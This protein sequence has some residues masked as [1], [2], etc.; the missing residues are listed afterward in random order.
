MSA[1]KA[2]TLLAGLSFLT[3]AGTAA[4]AAKEPVLNLQGQN[5]VQ[6]GIVVADAPA[7]AR[8]YG[9]LFGVGP[10]KFYD[11]ELTQTI[12]HGRPIADGESV[13]RV[14]LAETPG[15]QLALLQPLSGPSSEREFLE[16]RGVGIHHLGFGRVASHQAVL[17]RLA[18]RGVEVEMQGSIGG[19]VTFTYLGTQDRL[20]VIFELIDGEQ[21][22]VESAVEPWGT[23][24]PTPPPRVETRERPIVQVGIVVDDAE[25]TAHDYWDLFGIGPWAFV[26][27]VPPHIAEGVLHGVTMV[28]DADVRVRG[29]LATHGSLEIE[30]LEP[31]R[32]PS[33]HME[34]LQHYGPGAH[35]LSFGAVA[36][37]DEAVAA[38]RQE[39]I[40][41]EMTGLLGGTGIF[42]YMATQ[43]RLGTIFELVKVVSAGESSLKPYGF[44]PSPD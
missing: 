2:A 16:T 28:E 41:I 29:A 22:G 12:E 19:D 40:E 17:S 18:Q 15:L 11:L 37:H 33:T 34:F 5:I 26:D 20:G 23:Y 8:E 3:G 30:L 21:S 35:H 1:R 24:T 39:G 7:T 27:F 31:M 44:F 42:T 4:A 14:A 32:G 9:E 25:R 6:V 36:D 10:W 13:V 38:L 43:R